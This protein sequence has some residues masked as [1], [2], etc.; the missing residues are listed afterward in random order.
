MTQWIE[1]SAAI[2]AGGPRVP[3]ALVP[4]LSR[5]ARGM[6]VW[7]MLKTLGRQGIADLVSH[8]CACAALMAKRL[9]AVPGIRI[10][11][12]VVINQVIVEFGAGSAA[13]R[14]AATEAVIAEVQSAGVCFVGGASWHG[15]WVMR[16]SVSSVTRPRP[17]SNLRRRHHR[18]LAQGRS[19]HRA[20]RLKSKGRRPASRRPIDCY[21]AT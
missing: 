3:S 11:N 20:G 9:R 12:D 2:M 6:P 16:I 7:A 13:E 19:D 5:R 18:R 14:K 17:I 10:C 4:E 15:D 1:L 8:H 21:A